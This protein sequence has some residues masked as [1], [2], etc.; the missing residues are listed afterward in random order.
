MTMSAVAHH[1]VSILLRGD[2]ST[3][4]STAAHYFDMASQYAHLGDIAGTRYSLK[5]G[6]ALVRAA[7]HSFNELEELH[8]RKAEA[9]GAT[10]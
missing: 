4:A 10:T 2:L 1:D 9:S 5:C 3:N 8:A 7:I 6:A